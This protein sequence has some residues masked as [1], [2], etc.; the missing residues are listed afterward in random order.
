ML[1]SELFI[2]YL[3]AAA[4][5]GVARFISEQTRGADAGA[6]LL[7]ASG[8]A[9]A[10]PFVSLPVLLRY[11]AGWSAAKHVGAGTLTPDEQRVEAVKRRAL[12]ALRA[13]EDLLED[14]GA[15]ADETRRHALYAARE[16]VERYAGLALAAAG[17]DAEARPS[18]REMELCRIAGRG[19]DDLLIAG[20]CIHRRNVTRLL[21]HRE[22]ARHELIQALTAVRR[23]AH[24]A[25]ASCSMGHIRVADPERISEALQR[26]LA[27]VVEL[28][29]L[30]DDPATTAVLTRLLGEDSRA[31]A[32]EGEE[33]CTTQVAP[34]AFAARRLRATTSQGG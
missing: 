27:H 14:G 16:C 6:A 34:T 20:R 30:F 19:G 12:C 24:D 5:F 28:L 15:P 13:V 10:W 26:A 25:H 3:A 22:R 29:S 31:D 4:P 23:L 8:A 32:K 1:F 33:R 11:A 2:I 9:L 21:A 17:A 18:E 7:K